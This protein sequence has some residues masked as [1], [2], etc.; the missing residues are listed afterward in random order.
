VLEVVG[1]IDR[2]HAARPEF[3]VEAVTVL[4]GGG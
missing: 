1:E 3:T 2:G 4:Q